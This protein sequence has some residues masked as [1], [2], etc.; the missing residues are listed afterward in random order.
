MK[1]SILT[2]IALLVAF[3]LI[4]NKAMSQSDP[5]LN[6][7]EVNGSSYKNVTPD[8]IEINISLKESD[9]KGKISLSQ[10]E[11]TLINTV[12]S[13]GLDPEKDLKVTSQS[14]DYKKRTDVYQYKN[15][16]LT[17]NSANVVSE[18]FDLF[19]EAGIANAQVTNATRTDIEQIQDS[20]KVE[21]VK[22]AQANARL[23]AEAVGQKIGKAIYIQH[24]SAP[25][26]Y[27]GDEMI[28]TALAGRKSDVTM[29]DGPV[30]QF[31]DTRIQQQVTV[32][33][34]LE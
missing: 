1:K 5:K 4:P 15:Y 10:M 3:M 20:L 11:T 33:F 16:L 13:L 26:M 8:K 17:V 19:S 6:Y 32:R 9:S 31:K 28:V 24:Y 21:A 23:L 12:R 27:R 25:Y 30:L 2:V 22:N 29:G 18:L 14:S 7:V 34:I